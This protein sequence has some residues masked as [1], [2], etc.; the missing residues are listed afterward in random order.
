MVGFASENIALALKVQYTL[1][2]F[3]RPTDIEDIVTSNDL[4]LQALI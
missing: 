3:Y 4:M 1:I 2:S